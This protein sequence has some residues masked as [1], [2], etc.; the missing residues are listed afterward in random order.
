[1]ASGGLLV[2]WLVH[3]LNDWGV[4]GLI[5]IHFLYW[6]ITVVPVTRIQTCIV[7]DLRRDYIFIIIMTVRSQSSR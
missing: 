7:Y 4:W 1:M 6:D 5:P 3:S 2:K